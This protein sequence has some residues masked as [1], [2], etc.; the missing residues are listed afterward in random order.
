MTTRK[1]LEIKNE[2]KILNEHERNH[3]RTGSFHSN[4]HST[5]EIFKNMFMDNTELNVPVTQ[6]SPKIFHSD[7]SNK[8]SK[9][10][11]T[12]E[13]IKSLAKVSMKCDQTDLDPVKLKINCNTRR[14]GVR[15]KFRFVQRVLH[16]QDSSCEFK[17]RKDENL[18]FVN[19]SK[20]NDVKKELKMSENAHITTIYNNWSLNVSNIEDDSSVFENDFLLKGNKYSDE[21]IGRKYSLKKK[22]NSGCKGSDCFLVNRGHSFDQCISDD[23]MEE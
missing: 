11:R 9:I 10:E 4:T 15:R 12:E 6:L 20:V 5:H 17:P 8:M 2:P 7:S 18:Q 23:S 19:E 21:I 1:S 16:K 14:A 13:N 22:G 3:Q